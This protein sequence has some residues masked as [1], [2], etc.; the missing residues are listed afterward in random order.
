ML[1]NAVFNMPAIIIPTIIKAEKSLIKNQFL[2]SKTKFQ[3]V[4]TWD[5]RTEDIFS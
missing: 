3:T 5:E 4:H 1:E 2:S